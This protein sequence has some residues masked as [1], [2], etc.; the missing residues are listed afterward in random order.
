[1]QIQLMEGISKDQLQYFGA[2]SFTAVTGIADAHSSVPGAIF[3]SL[4]VKMFLLYGSIDFSNENPAA[5]LARVYKGII[6]TNPN[7]VKNMEEAAM[8]L[9]IKIY[10][11]YV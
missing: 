3:Y 4:S 11:D 7:T 2:I 5:S 9:K 10:S 6:Q 1:M 8:T